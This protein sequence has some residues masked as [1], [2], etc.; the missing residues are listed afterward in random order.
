[1]PRAKKLPGQAADPR[2]GQQLVLAAGERLAKFSLPRR[3]DKKP[4]DRRVRLMWDA[5]WRDERL[6][7][8]VLEADREVL[9]GWAQATDDAIK[10]LA[11]AWDSPISKGSMGQEVPSPYFGIA[12][13]AQ[14]LAER[15][16]RQLG[17]GALNRSNLG[18]TLV[19]EARSLADLSAAYPGDQP[20]SD[21][22]EG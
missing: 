9:I 11:L 7:S 3:P 1:M 4:Y 8:V 15:C 17:I 19:A 20:E 5:Y 22:R 16:G 10:A 21:P 2:N 18:Y 14:A 13:Q 12:A 6:S